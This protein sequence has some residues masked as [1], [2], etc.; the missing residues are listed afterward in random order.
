MKLGFVTCVQLGLSCMEAIYDA[1]GELVFAM[2]LPDDKAVNKSGRVYIDKFC[3]ARN[4]NLL[5]SSHVNNPEVLHAIKSL[6]IDWLF[7]IGWSQ[8]A[9]HDVLNAPKMGVLGMHPTLLPIGRGRAAIPWAILHGL[10]KTGVTMFKMDSGVDTGPVVAQLEIP[11][12]PNATATELYNKV[13]AAHVEL[14]HKVMPVLLLN[15]LNLIT[16]DESKATLWPGRKPEDGEINLN[17]SV[18]DADKLIRA[19]TKPYPGAFYFENK[20][21]RIVWSAKCICVDEFENLL[22]GIFLKFDDGVL[23]IQDYEEILVNESI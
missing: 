8:I 18:F 13:D 22:D 10:E 21:K 5:K 14:I 20:I 3:N 1:G 7:I 9:S 6:G 2:T 16:Q 11:L 4:I 17:G 15:K 19:V 12:S 23:L